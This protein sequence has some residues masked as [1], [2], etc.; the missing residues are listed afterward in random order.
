MNSIDE[1]KIPYGI[2]AEFENATDTIK[3]TDITLIKD[4]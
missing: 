3:K 2:M 4:L 1:Y